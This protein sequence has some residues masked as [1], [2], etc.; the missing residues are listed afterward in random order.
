MEKLSSEL[1]TKIKKNPCKTF[2]NSD[3]VIN[4]KKHK[5]SLLKQKI[6]PNLP[7]EFNGKIIWKN[8]LSD[9]SDQGKCGS[10][11]AW[12]STA[13]LADR[14]SLRTNNKLHPFLSPLRM[15]LCDLD[16]K[17]WN[18]KYPE[19]INYDSKLSHILSKNIGKIGCHGNTL[20]DAWR[21]LYT[22]GT[23]EKNCLSYKSKNRYDIVDYKNDDEL[24]LCTLITGLEGDMCGNYSL[25]K[26]TG[27]EFGEPARFFRAKSYYT[28][29][30]V[31]YQGGSD[32]NIMSEI[33]KNGPVTAGIEVY[34]DFYT[35]N[36]KTEIYENSSEI[37]VGGH[38]IKIVGWGKQNGKKFWWIA[39][40]WGKDW[41]IDGYF[42]MIRGKNNC[43]LES[44]VVA[45]LPDLFYPFNLIFDEE[46][47]KTI[48]NINEKARLERLTIDYGNG[49]DGGGIDIRTGFTRRSQY[50]YTGYDFSPLLSISYLIMLVNTPFTAGKLDI[51]ES[52]TDPKNTSS[53]IIEMFILIFC[54][55]SLTILIFICFTKTKINKKIHVK[56]LKF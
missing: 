47:Q 31:T 44:N 22:I 7:H 36:P 33:Y 21:Y 32:L 11:W 49:I 17:E 29:P 55:I 25:E 34:T 54:V 45:G 15:L 50:R 42:K 28:I 53:N 9:I 20:V 27:S 23:N 56:K 10:C 38:A 6:Y 43:K 48:D 30:G 41:G 12:A 24:P 13:T 3:N 1:I 35:F 14:I 39:N 46:T 5:A 40:S 52:Y 4:K 18:I 26:Q 2:L 16:G 37:R 19:F 51:I 8:Y